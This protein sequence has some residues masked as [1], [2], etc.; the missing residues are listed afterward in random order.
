MNADVVLTTC[1]YCGCGCQLFLEVFDGRMTGVVPCRTDP[2]SRGQP[3]IK[4]RNA[5]AFVDHE[6]RLRTPLIREGDKFREASWQE[7]LALVAEKLRQ[8]KSQHGPDSIGFVASARCTNEDNY[9]FMKLA[10]AVV[11]TNNVDHCARLCHSA[12]VAGLAA[13]FGSGA[14]TNSIVELEDADCILVVGSNTTE[15]HPLVASRIMAAR[16]R[17]AHLILVDPRNT[18][19]AEFADIHLRLRPGT[20][21]ALANAFMNVIIANGLEDSTLISE[22]TEG[23]DEMRAKVAEYTPERA[24]DI[25]GVSADDVKRAALL[26]GNAKRGSIVYCMGITQHTTGTDNVKAMANLAMLTGNVGRE[27]TGVNPLRGQNN[28][29]GACDMGALPEVLTGYQ[30]VSDEGVR[31]RFGEA[32]GCDLSAQPGLTLTEMF[33]AAHEGTLKSMFVM[34]ENP[35]LS[36]PDS[37]HAREALG[38]LEFLVAQDIF[39]SETAELAH[40]VLPAASFAEKE[41]T[42]T[43]TDRRVLR[44]RKAID[45]V[46]E[47]KPDWL[48]VCELA[49]AMGSQGFSFS[50]ASEIMGE[51]ATLTPSYGG[52][53][54]ERLDRGET[55]AW[56]CPTEEHPG[57]QFLHKDMFVRGKGKFFP[58]DYAPPAEAPDEQFPLVLT[59]GRVMFQYH[60]GTMT[61]RTPALER[62]SP[63]AFVEINAEDAGKLGISDGD[64]VS[65]KSRRGQIQ[66]SASVTDGVK[67]GV[68]FVPFHFA[69][70]AANILTLDR[71]DPVAKIPELKVCAVS[72]SKKV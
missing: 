9:V 38:K 29:Q 69:E 41:G 22:R 3:C 49:R 55:P 30:R 33:D 46:G 53:S 60:T 6:D 20:D 12:T 2:I 7:A 63:S 4:G 39:L 58:V 54:H 35:V 15:Q 43:S 28:V 13:S 32:W 11:G 47:S 71:R 51:I 61:R 48:I 10:R 31:A 16:D 40:V 66:L 25:C 64:T 37:N 23:Y 17:G 72:V 5:H 44:V 50:S 52:V 1:P 8:A 67:P 36:E 68:V 27:S 56:P 26:Y 34:G 45:P 24:A 57:T 19:L 42:F 62:E 70:A 14:M 65:V 59:T 18:P 21:I